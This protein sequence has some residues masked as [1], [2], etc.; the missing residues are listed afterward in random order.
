M[1][2]RPPRSTLFPYTTLFRAA[3]KTVTGTGFT[4]TGA[5]LANYKFAAGPFTTTADITKKE[6]TVVFTAQSRP[7]DGPTATPLLTEHLTRSVGGYDVDVTGGP[8]TFDTN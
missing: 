2:R 4:L 6:L 3:G 5:D 7:Y 1:I 8:A